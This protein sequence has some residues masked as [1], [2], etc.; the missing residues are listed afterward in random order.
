MGKVHMGAGMQVRHVSMMSKAH[1]HKGVERAQFS[2]LKS[3]SIGFNWLI[4]VKFSI[5][6]KGF[7]KPIIV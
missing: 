7:L 1:R 5:L 3:N 6:F 4:M 2:R